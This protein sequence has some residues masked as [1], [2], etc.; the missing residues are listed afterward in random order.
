MFLNQHKGDQ[1]PLCEYYSPYNMYSE[2]VGILE[3]QEVHHHHLD[4]VATKVVLYRVTTGVQMI[5]IQYTI[6]NH[7]HTQQMVLMNVRIITL[8]RHCWV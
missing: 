8:T 5:Q 2:V 3:H 1:N 6:I 4:I 7:I